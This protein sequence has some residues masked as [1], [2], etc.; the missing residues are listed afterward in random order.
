MPVA[1]AILVLTYVLIALQ[2]FLRTRLRMPSGALLGAAL[3]A[4][5]GGIPADKTLA[6][7]PA[8]I[9]LFLT[10]MLVIAVYLQAGNAVSYFSERAVGLANSPVKLVVFFAAAGAVVS[11]LALNLTAAILL[12]PLVL[13]TC[14]KTGERPVP[15][16]IALILG[17]NL[18]S[19]A[20]AMGS[21][22]TMLIVS[23]SGMGF[24]EYTSN[25]FFVSAAGT[26]AAI[27]WLIAIYGRSLRGRRFERTLSASVSHGLGF[28]GATSA[29]VS[30]GVILALLLGAPMPVAAMSGAAILIA[31]NP[32][33]PKD[34]LSIVNWPLVIFI[35]SLFVIVGAAADAGIAGWLGETA[36]PF[37]AAEAKAGM[38]IFV[39]A[40]TAL[41][42]L[43][44]GVPAAALV[45]PA[46]EGLDAPKAVWFAIA[47]ATTFA[48]NVT[49]Y[50]SLSNLSV[51]E[52]T[53]AYDEARIS[54][55]EFLRAGLPVTVITLA[56]GLAILSLGG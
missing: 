46:L 53:S 30:A 43:F 22:Q 5:F 24:W 16:I 39:A 45:S 20:T 36:M 2:R 6:H 4:V 3:M 13:S 37:L 35:G 56:I 40:L 49:L 52:Q 23:L 26:A 32:Q 29:V 17:I 50:G 9:L 1:A 19:A 34:V 10:G 33:P 41:T 55:M 8:E 28:T 31:I 27:V 38:A 15:Y 51:I 18:G 42:A 7:I 44:S 47:I 12:A 11:A 25:M 48:G 54:A 14:R 21:P